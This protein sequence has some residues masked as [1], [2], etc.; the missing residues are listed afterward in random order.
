MQCMCHSMIAYMAIAR[1]INHLWERDKIRDIPSGLNLSESH[2]EV[3][4]SAPS[5]ST[6]DAG[7]RA[8]ASKALRANAPPMLPASIVTSIKS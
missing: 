5:P 4:R 1:S 6:L 7:A 8:P 3:I 2:R